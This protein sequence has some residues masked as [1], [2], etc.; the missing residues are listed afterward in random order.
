LVAVLLCTAKFVPAEGPCNA[1]HKFSR[2][3]LQQQQ[4]LLLGVVIEAA[5][6]LLCT[7]VLL[8]VFWLR[9]VCALAKCAH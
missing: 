2:V 3:V 4:L 1:L 6:L 5:A 7:W 9:M 8:L